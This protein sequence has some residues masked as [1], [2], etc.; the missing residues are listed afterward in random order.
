MN[1]IIPNVKVNIT[2]FTYG[3]DDI[4]GLTKELNRL[5]PMGNVELTVT[6]S[7]ERVRYQEQRAA[8]RDMRNKEQQNKEISN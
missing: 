7:G 3:I 6:I 4:R 5:F 2:E 8:N 1:P